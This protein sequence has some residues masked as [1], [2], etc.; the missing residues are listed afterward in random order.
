MGNETSSESRS[1]RYTE[2]VTTAE[3]LKY[4][5]ATMKIKFDEI[6]SNFQIDETLPKSVENFISA[7]VIRNN[8]HRLNK[9]SGYVDDLEKDLTLLVVD[10]DNN[11]E[12]TTNLQRGDIVW[13]Q[14]GT[15]CS[16]ARISRV[17]NIMYNEIVINSATGQP[18]GRTIESIRDV[19]YYVNYETNGK[20]QP[21]ETSVKWEAITRSPHIFYKWC[22]EIEIMMV[23]VEKYVNSNYLRNITFVKKEYSKRLRTLSK[24]VS[25]GVTCKYNSLSYNSFAQNLVKRIQNLIDQSDKKVKD[26]ISRRDNKRWWH[27]G[28]SKKTL[29]KYAKSYR[30]FRDNTLV[31]MQRMVERSMEKYSDL[32]EELE[33]LWSYLQKDIKGVTSSGRLATDRIIFNSEGE[34]VDIEI[35]TKKLQQLKESVNRIHAN[36]KNSYNQR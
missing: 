12:I 1:D 23:L 21:S 16:K 18:T 11:L 8:G 15:Q 22:K 28:P 32:Y 2:T 19:N 27:I 35:A 7:Y 31:S 20:F 17:Q 6:N 34:V 24:N 14:N 25:S 9:C 36:I 30:V 5:D 33:T 26:Y 10:R 13:V 29:D 4:I 3:A